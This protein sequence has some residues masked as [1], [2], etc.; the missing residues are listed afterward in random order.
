MSFP[1]ACSN[2][3][4]SNNGIELCGMWKRY[5][6]PSF[7]IMDWRVLQEL[8]LEPEEAVEGLTLLD[9]D[10]VLQER[11]EKLQQTKAE[12]VE[13]LRNLQEKDEVCECA[14]KVV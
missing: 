13:E 12:R 2:V 3:I 14:I 9:L 1:M 7:N 5:T 8:V 11:L 4:V 10:A 6:K